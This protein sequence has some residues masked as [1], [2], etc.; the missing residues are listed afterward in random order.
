M[1]QHAALRA[2]GGPGGVDDRGQIIR[3]DGVRAT[4]D[5]AVVDVGAEFHQT[6]E[7]RLAVDRRD[8][9]DLAAVGAPITHT[10]EQQTHLVVLDDGNDG[11]AVFEDPGELFAGRRL[12]DGHGDRA[13]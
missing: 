4:F 7:T 10:V 6:V 5:L 9:H 13:C 3:D 2:A 8:G 11:S 12:V 1:R